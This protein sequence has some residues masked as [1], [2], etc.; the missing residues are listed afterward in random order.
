MHGADHVLLAV[1]KLSVN[2]SCSISRISRNLP[3]PLFLIE[4]ILN[5]TFLE[6]FLL[7]LA[8]IIRIPGECIE[9]NAEI[10]DA[11]YKYLL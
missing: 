10:I 3:N 5:A 8:E 11:E 1:N 7:T 4:L 6:L 2:K 9:I